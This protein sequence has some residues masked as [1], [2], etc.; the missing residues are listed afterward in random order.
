MR[1]LLPFDHL[2]HSVVD[3]LETGQQGRSEGM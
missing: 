3:A 2:H 1:M